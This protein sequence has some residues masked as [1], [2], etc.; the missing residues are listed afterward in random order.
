MY[1]YFFPETFDDF[2]KTAALQGAFCSTSKNH[3]KMRNLAISLIFTDINPQ[4]ML[5]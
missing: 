5:E 3:P 4:T 1:V 2:L